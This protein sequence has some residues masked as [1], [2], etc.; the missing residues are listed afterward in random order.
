MA[1]DPP[2]GLGNPKRG[3]P[4]TAQRGQVINKAIKAFYAGVGRGAYFNADLGHL[5]RA[6]VVDRR[7]YHA[8][9][10]GRGTGDGFFQFKLVEWKGSTKDWAAA[11]VNKADHTI[12]GEAWEVSGRKVIHLDEIVQ[13]RLSNQV[14]LDDGLPA[15][16]FT[17]QN[18]WIWAE[19]DGNAEIVADTNRWKL[20]WTE[21]VR[22][23]TGF[24]AP[25]WTALTG[26][27]TVDF[28]INGIEANNSATGVQG[29]GVD[30]DGADYPGGFDV[31]S[32]DQGS[33][34]V[35]LYENFD[36]SRNR[37]YTIAFENTDDGIC[38]AP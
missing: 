31:Q 9:L 26:S 29:H 27:T 37:F 25:V 28:A 8:R 30:V 24:G 3:A 19:L 1:L 23:T 38:E 13:L 35:K 22:T 12:L 18:R 4:I 14:V 36:A 5:G 15:L 2:I 20:S 34:I 11:V 21:K 6:P 17:S 32:P 33:P 16:E 7:T 10:T